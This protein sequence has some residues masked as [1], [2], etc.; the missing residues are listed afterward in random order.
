MKTL[1]TLILAIALLP[2]NSYALNLQVSRRDFKLATQT[3]ME[4]DSFNGPAAASTTTLFTDTATS[5]SVATTLTTFTAQP[6]SCRTLSFSPTG[7]TADISSGDVLVTGTNAA[8]ASFS[9]RVAFDANATAKKTTDKAFCTVASVV[10]E[11]QDGAAAT[12][13]GG[14]E[15]FFGTRRCMANAGQFIPAVFGGAFETT[16]PTVS[17]D[18]TVLESN[19]VLLNSTLDG[20]DVELFY[21]QNFRCLP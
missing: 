8:G 5:N 2:I 15:D 9:E 19:T 6:D 10:F 20:S 12:F 3:L 1:F 16:R 21:M 13:S 7:T 14:T 17:S 18:S 4:H 11:V